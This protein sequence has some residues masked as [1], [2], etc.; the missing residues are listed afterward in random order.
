[1]LTLLACT[2]GTASVPLA[3][4]PVPQS[5]PA[6]PAEATLSL[7]AYFALDDKYARPTDA[8]RSAWVQRLHDDLLAGTG[9][10][11]EVLTASGGGPHGAQWNADADLYVLAQTTLTAPLEATL[12]LT[13]APQPDLVAVIDARQGGTLIGFW[14]PQERWDAAAAPAEDPTSIV[15]IGV[16][17]VAAGERLEAGGDF[18]IAH[19]E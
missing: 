12:L 17:V 8:E 1:M 2:G 18:L 6:A 13:D 4:A 19:G 16:T 15:R 9:G 11:V 7:G 14:L 5:Q 10:H 3:P